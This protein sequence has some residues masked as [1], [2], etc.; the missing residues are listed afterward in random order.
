MGSIAPHSMTSYPIGP[1]VTLVFMVSFYEDARML[2]QAPA[3]FKLRCHRAHNRLN[4]KP[5]GGYRG[6]YRAA[7]RVG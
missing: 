5:R 6:E 7:K 4:I 1:K 2:G 3:V